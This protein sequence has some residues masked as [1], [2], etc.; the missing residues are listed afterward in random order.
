MTRKATRLLLS[1]FSIALVAFVT[2]GAADA[3]NSCIVAGKVSGN[4]TM[5]ANY[6]GR[7]I[8]MANTITLDCK[9]FSILGNGTGIGIDLTGRT[10][11]RLK[12]CTVA[13]HQ[14]DVYFSGSVSNTIDGGNYVDAYKIGSSGGH[15]IRL[16]MQ[17]TGNVFNYV[18]ALINDDAGAKLDDSSN[19]YFT[20]G[21]KILNQSDGID[22]DTSNGVNVY[23]Q[24]ASSN[25]E[26]GIE[27][28]IANG[29]DIY[30]NEA[31]ENGQQGISFDG[32]KDSYIEQA[33]AN[34]NVEGIKVKK[35]ILNGV[36]VL[37][38]DNQIVDNTSCRNTLKDFNVDGCPSPNMSGTN[39]CHSN[40]VGCQ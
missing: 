34:S 4:C 2:P 13:S 32:V 20:G 8:V 3:A 25:R 17:S 27:L 16:K 40:I 31:L 18:N 36:T 19:N 7:I 5:D 23:F 14:Y 30:Q 6:N 21:D 26:N 38:T 15:G 39:T 35:G 10:G 24:N 1:I 33:L 9:G 11:V 29:C 37:S 28:D 12:N 22:I